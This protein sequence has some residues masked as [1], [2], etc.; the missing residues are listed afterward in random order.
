MR[1]SD[2]SSDVCS[3]DLRPGNLRQHRAGVA[4]DQQR[5][6]RRLPF[7]RDRAVSRGGPPGCESLAM[8]EAG[9]MAQA[10]QVLSVRN[11]VKTFPIR[12]GVVLERTVGHVKA[13][14]D[15]SFDI[16]RGETMGLVGESGCGKSTLGR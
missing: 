16:G 8:S 10:D 6:P 2:W 15:V 5:R 13:V 4:P 14:S 11:L 9:V 7:R 3:S 1:I 12:S